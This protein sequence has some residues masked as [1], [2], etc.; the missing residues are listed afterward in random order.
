[1]QDKPIIINKKEQYNIIIVGA[2]GFGR[3]VY[4]WAKDS[5][6]KDKYYI[7]GFLDD[8]KLALD[9][10]NLDINI[11]GDVNN[12]LPKKYDRFIIAIGNIDNKKKIILSLKNKKAIFISLIHPTA[13]VAE[14]A[15]IGEGVIVCPFC[16][17]S[18]HV[19]LD[20]FVMLNVYSSCG[21]DAMI[22][23]YSILSSYSAVGGYAILEEEVFFGLKA[24]VIPGK[25]IKYKSK[26]SANSVVMRDVPTKRMVFGVPGKNI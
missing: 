2:G 6:P 14:N 23:R 25:R 3:E 4:L 21:H 5:F 22:G 7:K 15:T 9:G 1:V 8:N 24:T 18:D 13:I 20:D 17:V 11:I 10:F 19:I 16:I 12:Y 26:V